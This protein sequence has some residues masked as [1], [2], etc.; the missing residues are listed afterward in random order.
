MRRR[1]LLLLCPLIAGVFAIGSRAGFFSTASAQQPAARAARPAKKL[2]P[3]EIDPQSS[4]V[5]ILVGKTGLGHDHG[6]EGKIQSGR[7]KL[8]A[9]EKGGQIE[10]NLRSFVADT[11]TARAYVGLSGKTDQGT[12]DKVTKNMLG[13]AVLDVAN[14][15]TATFE[16]KSIARLKSREGEP[17][18]FQL[19]GDFTLHGAKNP[20]KFKALA[21][22]ADGFIHLRGAFGILQTDYGITPFSQ[23]FGAVGVAD[24]LTIYGD[25]WI[26]AGEVEEDETPVES[27][28][29]PNPKSAV[30]RR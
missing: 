5:Y 7:L 20:I 25:L 29:R 17:R 19:E 10:F 21:D 14:F 15:P 16:V 28:T 3:G 27:A 8:G 11:A 26:V 12:A 1:H 23:A 13:S 24:Q 9:T 18:Q 22:E 30:R 2:R 6:I 4:R